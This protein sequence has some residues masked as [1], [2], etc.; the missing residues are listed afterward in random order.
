MGAANFPFQ[1]QTSWQMSQPNTRLPMAGRSSSGIGPPELDGEVGDA[2]CGVHDGGSGVVAPEERAGGAGV[3]AASAGAAVVLAEGGGGRKGQVGEED[4]EE[5]VRPVPRVDEHGVSAEPAQAGER[6]ELPLKEGTRVD[7]RAALDGSP[8][9]ALE[10]A[11]ELVQ[12]LGDDVVVV[13]AAR[14]AGDDRAGTGRRVRRWGGGR[15]RNGQRPG[16][17]GMSAG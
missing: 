16:R 4:A 13:A 3:E 15:R 17:S 6:G 11:A 9:R 7:V 10:A 1:G 12:P 2:A 14:V 8:C 5:E